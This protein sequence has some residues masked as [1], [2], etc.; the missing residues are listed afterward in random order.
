[1]TKLQR[2]GALAGLAI[3]I[4]TLAWG[5]AFAQSATSSP[6]A[7]ASSTGEKVVFS[8]GLDS[9]ITSTNIWK[10]CCGPDFQYLGL[11]Y[12]TA[13]DYG[14][15]LS[16]APSIVTSWTPNEDSTVWTLKIRDDATFNDGTPVTAEDVAFSFQFVA[17]NDMPFYAVYLPFN[18]TFTAVDATTVEWKSEEPTFAPVVPAYIPIVPKHVWEQFVVPGDPGATR[19][20]A[21]EYENDNP[22]GSGP[23]TLAEYRKGEL[24]RFEARDDYWGG[25]PKSVQEVDFRI[26]QN[27]EAMV[28]AL[29]AGEIDFAYDL[30]P[31]L[32]NSPAVQDDSNI[33]THVSDGGC[34]GNIAW[35]FGGQGPDD[36]ADPIIHDTKFRQAMSMAINRDEIVHKVYNDTAVVG[37]SVTMPGMNGAWYHDIPADLQFNYD[38]TK[39]QQYLDEIGVVDSNGNGIREDPVTKQD[40]NLDI[41]TISDVTGSVDTGKLIAGYFGQVGIGASP[42]VVTEDKAYDL[43]YSGDWDAYVWDWCQEPD[44]DTVLSYFTTDACLSTSDGCYSNKEYD[45]LYNLQRTQLDHSQR[46]E[47][48]TQAQ[49]MLAEQVP[50]MVLN[51]WSTLEAYRTDRFTGYLPSPSI[52]SGSLILGWNNKSLFNLELVSNAS[53]GTTSTGLPAWAWIAI[54]VAI[55]AIAIAVVAMRR[56]KEGE[57]V[58]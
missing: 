27:Q 47:T 57:E 51:Y 58:A 55:A 19:K 12:D 13:F 25:T 29:K 38:P 11:V 10:L 44:P 7:A 2:I 53:T 18:P 36:S 24:I 3:L 46:L 23:F 4:S 1:M 21:R 22:I 33:A 43:W 40:I 17:D 16:V 50:T 9:D 56:K 34:W 6:S 41:L 31:T 37:H 49:D 14:D 45:K 28:S 52:E 8:Y 32:W 42:F 15:D 30:K 48:V 26:Y 20:A 35:N 54:V 5:P 39:A